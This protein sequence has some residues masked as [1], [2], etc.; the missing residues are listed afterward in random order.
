MRAGGDEINFIPSGSVVAEN[1]YGSSIFN[2][3]FKAADNLVLTG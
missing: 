2:K 1:D 3:D